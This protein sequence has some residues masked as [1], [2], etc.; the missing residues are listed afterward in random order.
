MEW[1]RRRAVA[2]ILLKPNI[3]RRQLAKDAL[4]KSLDRD[5]RLTFSE[6]YRADLDREPAAGKTLRRGTDDI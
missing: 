5:P 2:E 1:P 6:I 3:E 4:F